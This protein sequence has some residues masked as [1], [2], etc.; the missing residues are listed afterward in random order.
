MVLTVLLFGLSACG[1]LGP[2]PP[3][4]VVERAIATQLAQTQ[5]AL[6][7]QLA[8]STPQTPNFKLS[9]VK[10]AER[11]T[12]EPGD[13]PVYRVRGTYRAVIQLPSRQ[14]TEDSVF[15]IYVQAE[16]PPASSQSN[17]PIWYLRRPS[18][19]G[20]SRMALPG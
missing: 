20:W 5:Q 18:V 15:E 9:Q 13:S 12:V 2:V 17:A 16:M 3:Q 14:V 11:D 8:P 1:S 7:E 6:I 4:A 19:D 10:V